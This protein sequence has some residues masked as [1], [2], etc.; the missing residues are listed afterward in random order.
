VLDSI[1]DAVTVAT[2]D[3]K[4]V[5]ANA[6]AE[7]LFGFRAA[8]VVGQDGRQTIAAPEASED[9]DRIHECILKGERYSGRLTMSRRDGTTF[10][11]HLTAGPAHDEHGVLAA[12]VG[13]ISDETER[14]NLERDARTRALQAETLALLGV[15]A[16]RERMD[17]KVAGSRVVTE[18]V[19]A[20][21]RLLRADR[22][23]ML[24]LIASS[25]ALE[26]RV[27]SPRIDERVIL[28]RGSRSF[29]G[30]VALAR[31]VVVVDD[32][33]H[34]RRF[35]FHPMGG[36]APPASAIGAPVFAPSGIVGVLAAFNGTRDR[37]DHD[38]GHLIQCMANIIGTALL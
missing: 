7:R 21:R 37:F 22:A 34:D 28:P 10:V 3:G 23:M 14:A 32:F 5:Y 6:A 18:A 26:V 35:D 2:P 15:Q 27:S 33:E 1:S 4:L 30:Y 13:V 20:T 9:A 38:D 16:L 25:D 19:D 8:D 29:S 31:T 12:I 24:D 17:P 36:I 11:A